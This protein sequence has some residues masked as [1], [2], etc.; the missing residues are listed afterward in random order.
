MSRIKRN[1]QVVNWVLFILIWDFGTPSLN[2]HSWPWLAE[3]TF[4]CPGR[5]ELNLWKNV[6]NVLNVL[7]HPMTKLNI[8]PCF[9]YLQVLVHSLHLV[10]ES[11]LFTFCAFCYMT[12]SS[13]SFLSL[14]CSGFSHVHSELKLNWVFLSR[15]SDEWIQEYLRTHWTVNSVEV[16]LVPIPLINTTPGP[17][18]DS[19]KYWSDW[20]EINGG[21]IWHLPRLWN[22][23]NSFYRQRKTSITCN[24]H[25]D[26]IIPVSFVFI[27]IFSL[28]IASRNSSGTSANMLVKTFKKSLNLNSRN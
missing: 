22:V 21:E 16:G 10:Q 15:A 8:F 6:L 18:P 27:G 7:I 13:F 23:V 28:S 17:T 11:I 12:P 25:L 20:T 26:S 19:L 3:M 9:C 1:R 2:D 14:I 5:G 24:S 4:H